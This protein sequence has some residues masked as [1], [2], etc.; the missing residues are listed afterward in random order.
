M[1]N[2]GVKCDVCECIHNAECNQ[3][4]LDTIEVTH[5]KTGPDSIATPHFCKSFT[6]R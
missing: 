6:K 2:K 5:Q 4:T 3:C 1:N